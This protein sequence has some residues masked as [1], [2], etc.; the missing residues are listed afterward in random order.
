M[1]VADA[2]VTISLVVS[3]VSLL[4]A[5]VGLFVTVRRHQRDRPLLRLDCQPLPDSVNV[6]S[7]LLRNEGM[8]PA[9]IDEVAVVP[10]VPDDLEVEIQL[11]KEL[12]RKSSVPAQDG[13]R[14]EM[15]IAAHSD[16]GVEVGIVRVIAVALVGK[17]SYPLDIPVVITPRRGR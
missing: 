1:L 11:P 7:F 15:A 4:F 5:A 10:S 16:R 13:Y 6:F 12:P 8:S 3:V 2:A 9:T 14:W 17:S